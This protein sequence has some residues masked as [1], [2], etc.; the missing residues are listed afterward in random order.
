MTELQAHIAFARYDYPI[1]GAQGGDSMMGLFFANNDLRIISY[2]D[3]F[4]MGFTG[5]QVLHYSKF[6]K[7]GQLVVTVQP[8]MHRHGGLNQFVGPTSITKE[9]LSMN[10][11]SK[12]DKSACMT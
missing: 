9:R 2:L 5:S 3:Q 6:D 7:F 10:T 4:I 1:T 8:K 12:S 11:F